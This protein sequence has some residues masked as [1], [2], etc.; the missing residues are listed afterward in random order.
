MDGKP[1]WKIQLRIYKSEVLAA[2]PAVISWSAIIPAGDQ[3]NADE[4][5]VGYRAFL[6]VALGSLCGLAPS[7]LLPDRVIFAFQ[8]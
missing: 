4:A 8:G 6:R 7:F 5:R 3:K 2:E 1:F